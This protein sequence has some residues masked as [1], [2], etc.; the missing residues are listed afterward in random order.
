V[1]WARI[2]RKDINK[3]EIEKMM[4]VILERCKQDTY[5]DVLIERGDE[6]TLAQYIENHIL[7]E[8]VNEL[9]SEELH[10]IV[11]IVISIVS[12]EVP[13]SLSEQSEERLSDLSDGNVLSL[14]VER[15]ETG[16]SS[17]RIIPFRTRRE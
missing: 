5:L 16:G 14:S 17:S 6:I 12:Q 2:K 9:N 13:S 10:Q 7:Y 1:V 3:Q 4:H 15:K 11:G 8:Y